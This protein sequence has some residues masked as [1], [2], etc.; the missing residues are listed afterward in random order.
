MDPSALERFG[1]NLSG[2]ADGRGWDRILPG[3]R[4]V[5]V[6]A[7]GGPALWN[8]VLAAGFRPW[9]DPIDRWVSEAV[10]SVPADGGRWVL[11]AASPEVD[12]RTL[13]VAAGLGWPSRLGLVLHPVYGP[14]IGLRAAWFTEQRLEPTGPLSSRPA[15]EGCPAP[16]VAACPVG[17]PGER[18]DIGACVAFRGADPWCRATC[19]AR[20]ACPVG[21]EHRYPAEERRYHSA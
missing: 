11:S 16:C 8:A 18:F 7:S 10:A 9:R 13:A 4:S 15:C 12:F 20:D 19:H 2:V 6:V 3:C 14:W 21:A 17:A 1:L 5:V